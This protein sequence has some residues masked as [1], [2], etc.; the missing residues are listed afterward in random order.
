ME[1]QKYVHVPP[2]MMARASP[3]PGAENQTAAAGLE[4]V[5]ERRYAEEKQVRF[6][7]IGFPVLIACFHYNGQQR[8][9]RL[10]R[11]SQV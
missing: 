4:V 5:E 8:A 7:G 1:S 9:R 3:G 6:A 10:E 11:F 2:S